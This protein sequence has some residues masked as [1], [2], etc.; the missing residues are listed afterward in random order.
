MKTLKCKH[1][2]KEFPSDGTRRSASL[3]G[4][5]TR[6]C[7]SNPRREAIKAAMKLGSKKM[8]EIVNERNHEASLLDR[9]TKSMR[10]VEC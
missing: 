2:G 5:H 10:L 4:V 9:S 7:S 3:L 6:N 1:C 8:N